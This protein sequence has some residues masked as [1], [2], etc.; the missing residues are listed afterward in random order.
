[1]DLS[2]LGWGARVSVPIGHR[3]AFL[4]SARRSPPTSLYQDALDQFDVR[5]GPSARDKVAR[6]SGGVFPLAPTSAFTD[7][8]GKVELTLPAGDRVSVSVYDGRDDVNNSHDLALKAAGTAVAV[9]DPL[10][11]PTEAAVQVSDLEAWRGP[12]TQ[13]D[14]GPAVVS[15]GVDDVLDRALAVL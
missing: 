1:M 4:L 8:N 14:V 7:L 15:G 5:G 2:A 11:L 6:F 12:G 9:P 10:Q 13:C 3:V